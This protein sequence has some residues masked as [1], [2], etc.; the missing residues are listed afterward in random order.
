M[1]HQ[2]GSLPR[3]LRWA[4]QRWNASD[5]RAFHDTL[6]SGQQ[7]D[8]FTFA[9]PGYV[10]IRRFADLAE[11]RLGSARHAVDLGCGPGEITCELA[12]RHPDVRFTG[13]DHSTAAIARATDHA[14][15]LGLANITFVAADIATYD[16]QPKADIVTMFDAFHHVLD[17]AAFVRSLKA[18]RVFLIEP[19][20]DWLGG[21]ARTLELD[22]IVNA[23]DTI[24]ARILWQMGGPG[25]TGVSEG[26]GFRLKPEATGNPP[27][28]PVEH[29]YTFGDF[30]QYFEGF[31]L[32][33]QGTIAGVEDYPP[34]P[35][36]RAPLGEEVGRITYDTLVAI[37]ELLV[38]QNLDLHAKHW[39]IYAERGAAHSLR[40]PR[41]IGPADGESPLRL[42]GPYDVEYV[43]Y[44]GSA[45]APPSATVLSGVIFRNKGWRTW[46]STDPNG[47]VFLS[48]HW[49]DPNGAIV[50]DDGLRTPLP[51]AVAP[52][53]TCTMSCRIE[54][55][56]AA[57]SYVLAI[58]LVDE[59]ITW[60]SRAGARVL[61]VAFGVR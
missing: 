32:T 38:A 41:A 30:T 13:V 56:A 16:P 60:F 12:R 31:G 55:P 26:S 20:G 52:G 35:Y 2:L 7:Y 14:R 10:T 8:P 42:Q 53:D 3:R 24:R 21:W 61:K 27:G 48:Y 39:A 22:W 59:G 40:T 54:T 57:G 45:T 51:H 28:E 5:D 46:S 6:F 19:G 11:A 17:P 50:I 44:D 43:S 49:L 36:A 47:A 15:R 23:L 34:D 29:R 25:K 1:L 9:Y 58:D 33:A 4:L 18:D 37:E